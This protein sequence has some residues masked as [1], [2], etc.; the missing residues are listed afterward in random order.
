MLRLE[1]VGSQSN[2]V[3]RS[4]VDSLVPVIVVVWAV[5]RRGGPETAA[6]VGSQLSVE[7]LASAGGLERP[8]G[9]WRLLPPTQRLFPIHF[10]VEV[11]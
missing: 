7:A 6:F 2:L 9:A 3:P 11:G 10:L 1:T 5:A 4:F 8:S